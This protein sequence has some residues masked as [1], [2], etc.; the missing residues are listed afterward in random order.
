MK[1]FIYILISSSLF[2]VGCKGAEKEFRQGDYDQ[3]IEISVR[4][5]Q[6]NPE[7]ESYVLVLEEAFKRANERDLGYIRSLNMEGQP[8]RW[9]EIYQVYQGISR[10]Q[11]KIAPLL[12]LYIESENR[13][14]DLPFIDVVTELIEA[15]KKAG[16][17]LYALAQEKLSTGDRYDAREAYYALQK[18]KGLYTNYQDTDELIKQAQEQGSSRVGFRIEN[19]TDKTLGSRVSDAMDNLTPSSTQG[20]WYFIVPAGKGDDMTLVLRITEIESFPEQVR[21]NSYV[22]SRE[23]EDGWTY[24]YDDAGNIIKDSLGNSIKIPKYETITAVITETW[25]EKIATVEGEVRYLDSRGNVLKTLPVK[26]DGVF[27]NY[28]A[29]ATGYYDAISNASRQKLGGA[30]APFPGD[31][32]LIIQ[33]ML[34]FQDMANQAMQNWNDEILNQ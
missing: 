14:A 29:S 2:L 5:L 13:N 26:G 19:Y 12:P 28:F 4:K 18:I 15:K 27:Q 33:A 17:H 1:T 20:Q 9:E 3:A 10:R 11:N 21:T 22:D 8:D 32:E 23:V 16:A 7:K 24:A 30:P 25:Q 6:R 31:E 34:I